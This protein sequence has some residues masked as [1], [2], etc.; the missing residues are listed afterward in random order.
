MANESGITALGPE[1]IENLGTV[2]V[3][4]NVE[5]TEQ[6][7]SAFPQFTD[8]AKKAR[9]LEDFKNFKKGFKQAL[10]YIGQLGLDL[11]P[12]SGITE[13]S[14]QQ[15]DVVEG[16]KRLSFPKQVERTTE[17]AKEGKTTEAIV[18]GVDTA[19]TGV[20]GVGEG[21]MVAGAVLPSI[22][23]K[24]LAI[25][26]WGLYGFSKGG[27]AILRN[28]KTGKK[29]LA[30]FEGDS[31][32]GFDIKSIKIPENVE[33]DDT[34]KTLEDNIDIETVRT[35][36]I[37]TE[38]AIPDNIKDLDSTEAITSYVIAP[39]DVNRNQLIA[40]IENDPEV[41]AKTDKYLE[42][43]GFTEETV[44]VFRLI[45]PNKKGA[46]IGEESLISGS[47]T[48]ESNIATMRYFQGRGGGE[49]QLVRYDVPKSRIKLAM[50]GVK[51]DIKQSSNKIIKEK[52]IGQTEPVRTIADMRAEAM[53]G[54]RLKSKVTNPSKTAKELIDMQ[55]EVI[56]DVTG[57]EKNVYEG[58]PNEIFANPELENITKGKYKN[59][60]EMQSDMPGNRDYT[61]RR[62][63]ED[64]MS[65]KITAEEFRKIKNDRAKEAYDK[66]TNFYKLDAPKQDEG[67][68]ALG[69]KTIE[70]IIK[71][72]GEIR[73]QGGFIFSPE[74]TQKNLRLQKTRLKKLKE[75]IQTAGE[76]KNK[77]IVLKSDNPNNPDFAIGKIDF[78]DWTK[79]VEKVLSDDE[80][81]G[82]TNW[83][84]EVYDYFKSAPYI[85]SEEEA[86]TLAQAWFAGAQRKSPQKALANVLSIRS[87]LRQGNTP[88]EILAMDKIE[89]G[90]LE[91]ATKAIL[92][93]LTGRE[94]SGVG[95]K[96]SDFRDNLDNKNVRSVMG[97]DPEGG[98]P[99]TVDV[100]TA[101]DMG[102]VDPPL[103]NLLKD[104]G[105]KIPDNIIDDFGD[106]GLSNDLY[107]NRAIFG[108]EL[109]DHLNKI[110]WKGKDD[111][112]PSEIQ[113]IGWTTLTNLYGGVNTAGNI[114][115]A[116][117][118]NVRRVSMEV[119]PGSGSPWDKMFGKDY[120]ELPISDQIK[121]NDEITNE[122]INDIAKS[123]NVDLYNNVFGTGGWQTYVNPST[124]QEILGIK[125][126]AIRIGAKLGYV[127]NQTEIYINGSKALTKN[128]QAYTYDLVERDSTKL[129]DS[130]YIND[131]FTQIYEKTNGVI[132]GFQPIETID[133]KIGIRMIVG[134]DTVN[135]FYKDKKIPKKGNESKK[136]QFF[137]KDL[138]K[139]IED[140]IKNTDEE[141]D[142]FTTES[143][144]TVLKN[145][146]KNKGEEDGQNYKQY[147]SK[148]TVTDGTTES[149]RVL[150]NIRQKLTDSFR[151]KIRN[152]QGTKR[153][154]TEEVLVSEDIGT[155]DIP[156]KS[157]GGFI[158]RNTYDW[159]YR[160]A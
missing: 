98:Q 63:I 160:D 6:K 39:E 8:E 94:A 84:S 101:R 154:D 19:L 16:G 85:K 95:F 140:V 58:N 105:Y 116:L 90:G 32:T 96:L 133:N 150:D 18:S 119:A 64:A 33:S 117:N 50:G 126:E 153:P 21:M 138:Q 132:V 100:H 56:A 137:E 106:G 158:E 13:I 67:I 47:L 120:S 42:E 62:D 49:K 110:K 104:K 69:P 72:K 92:S 156:K 123:E 144:L 124:V 41:K 61:T 127:L 91:G 54:G 36:D 27:R 53:G 81:K 135:Q 149:D 57:L 45:T 7:E 145:D 23:G 141:F 38:V 29:I 125:S 37:D 22:Y 88:E 35:D 68:K 134:P 31:Q 46:E 122:A 11:V 148:K 30:D 151:D 76:P 79:R 3:S 159:V 52:K 130:K 143:D 59:Y 146:W 15:I 103:L 115:D 107:Q 113:A 1:D 60:K 86:K 26:G 109:T 77:R 128:P 155:K 147:F 136:N 14:G 93:V 129:R 82:A 111:W 97:N 2:E 43:K 131:L 66:V 28:T 70:D 55:D 73:S 51:N 99:F 157:I 87:L 20:A 48:P 114:K 80:I 102:L 34:I 24:A 9:G 75:G 4:P 108:L 65:K 74:V 139:Q 121:I 142:L 10:P 89:E 112:Q 17:L 118:L 78:D 152:A 40:K 12:G 71:P 5:G 44:P 25:A 83:Y